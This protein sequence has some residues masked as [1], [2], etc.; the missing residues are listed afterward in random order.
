MNNKDYRF[1]TRKKVVAI[2]VG[3]VSLLAA[4]TSAYSATCANHGD[5][6]P[7]WNNSASRSAITQF[8]S[9]VTTTGNPDYVKPTARIAVID[10]DGTLWPEKPTYTQFLFAFSQIKHESAQHPEWKTET[11]Y[12]WVLDNNTKAIFAKG[13]GALLPILATSQAGLTPDQYNKDVLNWL[14]TA[15]SPRFKRPYTDLVYQPMI[16]LIDYLHAHK[17][18]VF[19]VTGAGGA[20]IKPWSEAIYH[21]PAENVIGTTFGYTYK[22]GTLIKNDKLVYIDDGPQKAINIATIIGKRPILAVGNSTGDKAM[23]SWTT[24]QKGASLGMLIHHTDAKR[25]WQYGADS[26]EGKFTPALMQAA[27]QHHWQVVDMKKDWCQIF[28]TKA[29]RRPL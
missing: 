17:F 29:E 2:W 24:S 7:L 16:E 12:K 14:S 8:V 15:Q 18:K 1:V 11:P 9:E 26:F 23:L 21:I 5:V 28:P 3:V 25:E 22:N 6:L 13:W 19:I 4:S 27:K 20:F 10:N